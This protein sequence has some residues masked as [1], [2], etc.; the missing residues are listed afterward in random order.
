M[1]AS[2]SSDS[3]AKLAQRRT[4]AARS[5]T[6]VLAARRDVRDDLLGEHVERVAQVARGLD[7]AREHAA[8]HDRRLEQVAAVLRVDRALARLADLVP[9][10][11]DALQPAADRTRRL[12]LDH[13]VDRTHVDAELEA[14]GGHD[15]PQVTALEVVLDH[16]ALLTGERAVVGA[17]QLLAEAPGLRVDADATLLG[18]L[19]EL[20]G[21]PLGLPAGVAE[22]DRRAVLEHLVEDPR[23][24]ARPDAGPP[25][26]RRRLRAGRHLDRLAAE[27]AHVLDRDDDLDLQGL[28]DAGIH[29][30]DRPRLT[31]RRPP[32]EEARHLL[33]RSLRGRQ[34]DALRRAGRDLLEPLEGQGEVGPA[35]GRGEG[36]DLVDDH[37]L[38]ADERL[39]GGRRQHQVQALG[40][41]DQQVRRAPDE[42]LAVARGGV[43]GAHGDLGR[44]DG[45]ADALGGEG[46][47]GERSPQVLL[48]VEREGPEGRDVE[49]P[50]PARP[51]LERWARDERVDGRQERGERLAAARRGADE[52]VLARRDRRPPHGSGPR[53]ARG[54]TRRTRPARRAR[55]TRARRDQR[56]GHPNEG[57]SQRQ[58]VR[59]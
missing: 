28:A 47:A 45:L 31:G 11:A 46:D 8:H 23:V 6:G 37:R 42:A 7:L 44:D 21:E 12:D 4:S 26:R 43:A 1:F 9:G 20:G 18:Q 49:D 15:R 22:D 39:R 50:G 48:D 41:R 16:D 57:V 25:G 53:S 52:G 29:D 34:P 17:D 2:C 32:A 3:S 33:Q 35:L 38:D 56:W 59:P 36:V 13:E 19:V 10:A 5:A 24:D 54:R 14:A 58:F 30:G 27:V 40:C 51:V 55:T